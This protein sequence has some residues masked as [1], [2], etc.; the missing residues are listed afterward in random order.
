MNQNSFEEEHNLKQDFLESSSSRNL[1]EEFAFYKNEKG[2]CVKKEEYFPAEYTIEK[3]L[4]LL[5]KDPEF[6][7]DNKKVSDY[8][9]YLADK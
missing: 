8:E 3:V 9:V 6:N 2:N 4:K 1:S 5:L 7:Q